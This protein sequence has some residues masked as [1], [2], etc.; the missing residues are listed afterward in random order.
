V[1]L[2]SKRLAKV[3]RNIRT[4]KARIARSRD[5][6]RDFLSEVEEICD[7]ADDAVDDIERALDTLSKYL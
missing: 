6:L 2:D 7:D 5:K 3:I 4:E 1:S